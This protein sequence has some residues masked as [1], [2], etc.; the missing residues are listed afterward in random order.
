MIVTFPLYVFINNEFDNMLFCLS[1]PVSNVA[2]DRVNYVV[3][4]IGTQFCLE[5]CEK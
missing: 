1:K 5:Y 2:S 3:K 4:C